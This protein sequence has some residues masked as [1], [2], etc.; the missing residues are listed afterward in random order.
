MYLRKNFTVLPEDHRQQHIKYLLEVVAANPH[1][2]SQPSLE[3]S[4]GGTHNLCRGSSV[5]H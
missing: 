1:S 2:G 5:T 3:V 4:D